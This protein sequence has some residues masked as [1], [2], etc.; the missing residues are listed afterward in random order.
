MSFDNLWVGDLGGD[1]NSDYGNAHVYDAAP[2]VGDTY[3]AANGNFIV[4]LTWT[5]TVS[6]VD[7]MFRRVDDIHTWLVRLD[8]GGSTFK[9]IS[10]NGSETE[11]ASVAFSWVEGVDYTIQ[12]LCHSIDTSHGIRAMVNDLAASMLAATTN[13]NPTATG[14]KVPGGKNLAIWSKEIEVIL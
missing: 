7:V 6:P 5:A 1:W 3:H 14:V 8:P 2:E 13:F 10:V 11:R 12:I 9:L 4:E